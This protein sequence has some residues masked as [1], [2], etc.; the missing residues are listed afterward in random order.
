MSKMNTIQITDLMFKDVE[1]H[2]LK[3]SKVFD[4]T[5]AYTEAVSKLNETTEKVKALD[6]DLW[7][8]LDSDIIN[9]EVVARDTAFNEG[10][11]LAVKLILSS[12]Q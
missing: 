11:K 1:E 8:E 4:S 10:F 5:P 6:R 7:F 9:V 12:I 3:L 2:D